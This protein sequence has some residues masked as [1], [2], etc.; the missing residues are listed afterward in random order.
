M[1][2]LLWFSA[3][4]L[5]AIIINSCEKQELQNKTDEQ[6]KFE[7]LNIVA[8]DLPKLK[9][10][11]GMIWFENAE[12]Y[13]KV[14]KILSTM[15]FEEKIKWEESIDF[16][17]LNSIYNKAYD[18]LNST[19]NKDYFNTI[20][21][22]YSHLFN[23]EK[24]NNDIT[25]TDKYCITS[26]TNICNDKNLYRIGDLVYKILPE[27]EL[28][29]NHNNYKELL[30]YD[31]SN[32]TKNTKL[33]NILVF[34]MNIQKNRYYN[35]TEQKS[36][37][38]QYNY[39]QNSDQAKAYFINADHNRVCWIELFRYA[40]A[41]YSQTL[42]ETKIEK[43]FTVKTWGQ[44][45]VWNTWFKYNTPLTLNV[46]KISIAGKNYSNYSTKTAKI[47]SYGKIYNS[48][49]HNG[50]L[51]SGSHDHF[52]KYRAKATSQGISGYWVDV[53]YNY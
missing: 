11:D 48:V 35:N 29:T 24:L 9:T 53:S 45:K 25:L 38:F 27:I 39:Y 51:G 22:K 34:D 3:I 5:F 20:L 8:E 28:M 50:Y 14:S 30:L 46:I 19:I 23:I 16:V 40:I 37:A 49:T 32:T 36:S 7:E 44:K 47:L 10:F 6:N 17:S 15:S 31:E 18:E 33:E 41:T 21:S 52:S 2:K 4:V 1:K 26:L 12:Q 13:S 42:N 43:G